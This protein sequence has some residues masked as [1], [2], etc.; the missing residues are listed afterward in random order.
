[1]PWTV[2]RW[3]FALLMFWSNQGKEAELLVFSVLAGP[4]QDS[5]SPAWSWKI[6]VENITPPPALAQ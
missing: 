6:E 3:T 1:V 5:S 2:I 4:S